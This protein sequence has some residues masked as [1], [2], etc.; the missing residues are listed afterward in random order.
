[1]LKLLIWVGVVAL[2][3]ALWRSPELVGQIADR[4]DSEMAA[5]ATGFAGGQ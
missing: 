2:V 5:I 1:M 3:I 4:L